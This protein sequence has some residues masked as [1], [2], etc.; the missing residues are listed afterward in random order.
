[1]K[2]T[3]TATLDIPQLNE[4]VKAAHIFPAMENNSLLSVGQLCDEG[5]FVLFSIDEVKILNEK[6]KIIMKGNRDCATGLWRI[7]VYHKKPNCNIAQKQ[8]QIHSANNVYALRNTGALV[9]YLHKAMFNCTKSA[10]VHAVKNGYLSTWLGLTLEAIN[11][12]LK[13]TIAT[14]M[15]HMN[16]KQQNIRSTKEK[17][18]E[19]ENEDITPL[20]QVKNTHLVFV[21][22]LDQGQIYTDL[23]GSFPTRSSKGKKG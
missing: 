23:T 13:F 11:K 12:H 19:A 6:Q 20:G 21:V 3:H 22:V 2:S 7:N 4:S 16:Q 8:R 18:L 5:Y 10:L 17:L 15:V 1:M 9:N 14:A